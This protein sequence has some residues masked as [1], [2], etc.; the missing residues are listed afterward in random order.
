VPRSGHRNVYSTR[1]G[2]TYLGPWWRSLSTAQA[3]H[4][5]LDGDRWEGTYHL[6]DVSK[7]HRSPGN[8]I[9]L[10]PPPGEP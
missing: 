6:R 1:H 3:C 5:C 10:Y 9:K 4:S 2:H 7:D 8:V